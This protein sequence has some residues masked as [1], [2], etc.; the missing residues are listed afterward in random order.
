LGLPYEKGGRG[1]TLDCIGLVYLCAEAAGEP[2][3]EDWTRWRSLVEMVCEPMPGD[4]GVCTHYGQPHIII[5]SAE[6]KAWSTDQKF[7]VA[8]IPLRAFPDTRY[9]RFLK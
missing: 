5:V 3:P 1:E 2:L 4:L 9:Y 6:Q 8:Q 7:G